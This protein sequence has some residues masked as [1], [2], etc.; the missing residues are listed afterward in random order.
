MNRRVP[1]KRVHIHDY[2]KLSPDLV[3]DAVESLG[4]ISDLRIFALNSYENRVY[5][6]GIEPQPDEKADP[7]IA[8]FYR[9]GRWSDEQIIE[10]HEF[11]QALHELEIPV[12]PPIQLNDKT[13]FSFQDFRF[14]LYPR[15]G[16]HAPELE[17]LD[18]LYRLGQYLGRVHAL[19][20]TKIF[21]YRPELTPQVFGSDARDYILDNKVIPTSLR[22]SYSTLTAHLLEKINN[23]F[24]TV[25]YQTIR[26]HGDFHPGNI[27][28][29]PDSLYLVDLDDARNG[30]AVQDLWMMLSGETQQRRSQLSNIIEGYEEFNEF[31]YSEFK[32]IE[33]LRTLRLMHYAGWLAKRWQDPAFP[34]AFPWFNTERYWAEHIL[35]LREQM[36]ELDAPTLSI[37]N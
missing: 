21:Q 36:F 37:Q 20:K 3:L 27:L 18:T 32:L 8:K 24:A 26:L 14:A 25:K 30:P 31:D 15:M 12:I 28:V 34:I 1:G 6:V 17:D 16:G 11:S 2:A 22:E 10:E 7:I 35:E 19:G 13:L 33:A 4:Y 29:R 23:L 9:P 5:Q